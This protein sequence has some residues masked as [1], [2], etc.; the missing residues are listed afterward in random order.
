M[1]KRISP[2]KSWLINK[3]CEVKGGERVDTTEQGIVLVSLGLN[4]TLGIYGNYLEIQNLMSHKF[5]VGF[6]GKAAQLEF[7]WIQETSFLII[8]I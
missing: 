4:L 5:H 1:Q 3:G 8:Q 7:H 2:A 6:E